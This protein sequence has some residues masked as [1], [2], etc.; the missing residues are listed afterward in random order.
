M[1][2]EFKA[3]KD[4]ALN[5]IDKFASEKAGITRSQIHHLIEEGLITV[6]GKQAK[7]NYRMHEGDLVDITLPEKSPEEL[8]PEDIPI[9]V[10]YSDEHLVV[11]NKPA[12]LV[13]YPAAGHPGGTLMNAIRFRFGEL[14]APGAPLRPGVVHRLDKDTS[15]IMVVALSEEAYHNLVEQFSER[16]I[17]RSYVAL[18]WGNLKGDKGKI[19]L[20]IGRSMTDRKKMSV[21]TRKGKEAE[22]SW[23][24]LERFKG[25]TMVRAKLSTGRTHQIRVHFS[26]EGHPVLG[27]ET[28][29]HKTSIKL[30]GKEK[31]SIPRQ[32]LH[33]KVLGFRHPVTGK[34]MRFTSPLPEDMSEVLSALRAEMPDEEASN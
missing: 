15:G 34:K 31:L 11:V 8:V 27:D 30:G 26:A 2:V 5:R 23:D 16:E 18:L 17:K 9:D 32:M 4:D 28:Y 21:R 20:K 19:K 13:V 29:G 12:G 22:T 1:I 3:S 33:A 25:A 24:V 10:L 14:T 7:A 6:N